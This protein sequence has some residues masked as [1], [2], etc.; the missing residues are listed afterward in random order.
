MKLWLWW[1]KEL[2][3]LFVSILIIIAVPTVIF[4]IW[5]GKFRYQYITEINNL[6]DVLQWDSRKW[7]PYETY[8]VLPVNQDITLTGKSFIY[9][10]NSYH[11]IEIDVVSWELESLG[12]NTFEYRWDW[13]LDF[14]ERYASVHQAKYQWFWC[15][16]K[17]C[18]LYQKEDDIDMPKCWLFRWNPRSYQ[19][20]EDEIQ[21]WENPNNCKLIVF[22]YDPSNWN[23]NWIFWFRGKFDKEVVLHI[24]EIERNDAGVQDKYLIDPIQLREKRAEH[25]VETTIAT[26][27]FWNTGYLYTYTWPNLW[28]KI[29]TPID[30]EPY[31]SE[32]TD[33]DFLILSWKKI[34]TNLRPIE[35]SDKV[36]IYWKSA[37]EPLKSVI[38]RKHMD[39]W[40]WCTLYDVNQFTKLVTWYDEWY[41]IFKKSSEN[42]RDM[43][44]CIT[45]PEFWTREMPTNY[46][47]SPSDPTRYYK[48]V[49]V[50]CWGNCRF[51]WKVE[52]F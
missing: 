2:W 28:I 46:Y 6:T 40:T 17:W 43:I 10:I 37:N 25:S 48:I 13:F 11:D 30:Y 31:F 15:T 38:E 23:Q 9:Y 3:R 33:K 49:P 32:K 8:E 27:Q 45:D 50:D 1:E 19:S 41:A 42:T 18:H 7:S 35:I 4:L 52:L 21:E 47:Q 51:I 26:W 14:N 39:T 5:S 34:I 20:L 16:K 29:T 24:T 22:P 12:Y 44:E 36:E